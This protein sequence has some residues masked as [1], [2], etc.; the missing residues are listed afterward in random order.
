MSL[1]LPTQ[2]P[3]GAAYYIVFGLLAFLS[4]API[5]FALGATLPGPWGPLSPIPLS[6][7]QRTLVGLLG[8]IVFGFSMRM[9]IRGPSV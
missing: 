9:L 8:L 7:V 3:P 2:L 4:F 6:E 1:N 5:A